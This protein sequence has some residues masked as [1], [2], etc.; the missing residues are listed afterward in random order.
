MIQNAIAGVVEG[1]DLSEEHMMEVMNE[2]TEGNLTPAQVGAFLVAMRM[3]GETVEEIT[4]AARVMRAKCTRIP[5]DMPD[6]AASAAALVDTCGTG[7]DG[8]NTFNVSTTAA[9]VV[10]GAGVKVAKH[11]N[12]SVSSRCGS[13]DVMEALGVRLDL[14]PE[15]VAQCIED[16][17]IG[18]LYAPLLHGAM[19]HVIG[20]RREI[21]LR[22]LFNLLGPLTNPAGASVQVVGLYR[23]DLT[24]TIA[25]VLGRLGSR[26]AFVVHGEGCFDEITV[27]G[28][29][30]VS[31]L[32]QGAVSTFTVTPEDVG[33]HTCPA[34][35]LRGGD[36]AVN[37]GITLSVLKGDRGGRR[38][39]VLMNAAAALT[40]AGCTPSLKDGVDMAA[41]SVDSGKALG[42]LDDLRALSASFGE[43]RR[44]ATA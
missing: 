7:G 3:K 14:D 11:G 30:K 2:I 15:Q 20:P 44:A 29:T 39:M 35:K 5:L 22:T 13:A 26:S 9:F 10:A 27:T 38:D 12:R 19:R 42:K 1:K 21:G 6:D 37:A 17:G 33:L 40:A 28:P 32:H 43:E 23:E 8:A 36:A 16:V 24:E 41:E 18:F 25:T 4:G 31:R 34:G